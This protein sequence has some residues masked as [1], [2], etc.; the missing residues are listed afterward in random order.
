MIIERRGSAKNRAKNASS[1][2]SLALLPAFTGA[3]NRPS[4]AQSTIL[5]AVRASARIGG[6]ILRCSPSNETARAGA[7]LRQTLCS[8][9]RR[10]RGLHQRSLALSEPSRGRRGG[11]RR[12]WRTAARLHGGHTHGR[13]AG[14][15]K[16]GIGPTAAGLF[17]NSASSEAPQRL[18]L[19][20][21]SAT[22][23]R[24]RNGAEVL[25]NLGRGAGR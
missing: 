12:G 16:G 14:R 11:G 7:Q 17:S 24:R 19:R 3:L 5:A 10:E 6:F 13:R 22:G 18:W 21:F 23:R 1:A 25:R 20:E 8:L 15:L 4:T 2:N 9:V